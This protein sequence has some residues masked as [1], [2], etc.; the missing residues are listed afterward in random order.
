MICVILSLLYNLI[1]TYPIKYEEHIFETT[2]ARR[3]QHGHFVVFLCLTRISKMGMAGLKP[4][5]CLLKPSK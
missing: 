2:H 4:A 3:Q 1:P 5:V